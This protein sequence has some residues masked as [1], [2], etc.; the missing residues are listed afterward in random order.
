MSSNQFNP[1]ADFFARTTFRFQGKE[2]QHGEEFKPERID[3]KKLALLYDNRKIA[4]EWQLS[5]YTTKPKP[6][7]NKKKVAKKAKSS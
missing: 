4:Y 6:A 3:S 2:Y 7:S 1:E 5:G